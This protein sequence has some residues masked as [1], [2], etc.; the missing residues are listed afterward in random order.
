MIIVLA[1][2]SC[3]AAADTAK[4]QPRRSKPRFDFANLARAVLAESK[5]S[6]GA[7]VNNNNNVSRDAT[8]ISHAAPHLNTGRYDNLFTFFMAVFLLFHGINLPL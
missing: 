7:N 5:R 8:I 1:E 2:D 6:K 4:R 3:G